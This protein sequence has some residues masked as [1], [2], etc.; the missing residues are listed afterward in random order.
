MHKQLA[1]PR[2]APPD[3]QNL[4]DYGVF[5]LHYVSDTE[6][7]HDYGLFK[8]ISKPFRHTLIERKRPFG[9]ILAPCPCI[10]VRSASRLKNNRVGREL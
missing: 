9:S 1:V 5:F 7:R 10:V 3:T 2:M 6:K 8:A 4:R